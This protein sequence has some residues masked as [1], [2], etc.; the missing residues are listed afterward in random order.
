MRVG[1]H[2]LTALELAGTLGPLELV[3]KRRGSR[4]PRK[5]LVSKALLRN[6]KV[7]IYDSCG[8]SR[9]AR[10]IFASYSLNARLRP[11]NHIPVLPR[12]AIE[13]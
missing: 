8:S 13:T 12:L 10:Q 4:F 2:L 7:V 1:L 5:G 3:G 6:L 9:D 11:Q